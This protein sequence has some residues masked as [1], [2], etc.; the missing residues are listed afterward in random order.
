MLKGKKIV[1]M[2]RKKPQKKAMPAGEDLPI[3]EAVRG[4]D[5]ASAPVSHSDSDSAPKVW[6][7]MAGAL[8]Y[9]D[10]KQPKVSSKSKESK[11]KRP[12]IESDSDDLPDSGIRGG[13]TW[14]DV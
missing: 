8:G 12:A 7:T 5:K 10:K 4:L 13:V 3:K 9:P 14:R 6:F 11:Y 2:Y 1:F